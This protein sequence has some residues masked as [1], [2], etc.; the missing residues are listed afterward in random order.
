MCL[1]KETFLDLYFQYL[2][3]QIIV[4]PLV[5]IF[6]NILTTFC[7]TYFLFFYFIDLQFCCLAYL[8]SITAFFF[9]W[10]L[11]LSSCLVLHDTCLCLSCF[12]IMNP[13]FIL[14][15][16]RWPCL[17]TATVLRWLLSLLYILLLL[18]LVLLCLLCLFI[19]EGYGPAS[20][21]CSLLTP[22][23]WHLL[24]LAVTVWPLIYN[25]WNHIYIY[26]V[27]RHFWPKWFTRRRI[28]HQATKTNS[29]STS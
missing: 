8:G 4:A 28:S 16:L 19:V 6:L 11:S 22:A 2:L 25:H 24:I 26:V 13:V 14:V 9:S 15:V 20:W 1:T 27:S 5:D 21:L 12:D 17:I 10:F 23:V 29:W 18:T 7:F 3:E